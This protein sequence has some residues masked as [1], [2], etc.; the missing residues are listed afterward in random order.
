M[1]SL[2]R[3]AAGI[4]GW[5][6]PLA[7]GLS[8]SL[9][10]CDNDPTGPISG[11]GPE[12]EPQLASGCWTFLGLEDQTITA[13]AETPAGLFAGTQSG[14]LFR[15]RPQGDRWEQ[16]GFD[17]FFVFALLFVPGPTPRLLVGVEQKV[18]EGT[19]L[20]P[21]F[22]STD[23]GDTWIPWDGGLVEQFPGIVMSGFSLA[24]D[25][26]DPER[27]YMGGAGNQL[28]S[29]DGGRSWEF[30]DEFGKPAGGGITNSMVVSP[31]RDGRVWAGGE[32]G[33][34]NPFLIRSEDWGDTWE[35]SFPDFS[36]LS[37][38][39]AVFD[40]AV[41][42]IDPQRVWIAAPAPGLG[43][44]VFRSDDAGHTWELVLEATPVF[45]VL[46]NSD[47]LYAAGGT[48]L[49]DPPEGSGTG[50]A[51]S[52]L[53]LFRSNDGGSTWSMLAAPAEAGGA[54]TAAFD[55]QGRLLIGTIQID[56][57][58]RGGVWR[59]EPSS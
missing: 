46:G 11:P 39:G 32:G 59:L 18:F 14:G 35:L 12:C 22:A 54:R 53:G 31:H 17:D 7:L 44:G 45:R 15:L 26:G 47:E 24:I 50:Q 4:P 49:R 42:D 19:G 9:L 58:Q 48:N 55:S 21:V 3:R 40:V 28:R 13:L 52:D 51:L 30:I 43:V 1:T 25:P 10:S 2:P 37:G 56:G 20:P 5:Q 8:L 27:L 38:D 57:L 41:D 16:V 34:F 23:G 6:A 36:Q 29:I 33:V